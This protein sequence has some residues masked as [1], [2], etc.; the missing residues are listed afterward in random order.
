MEW[1]EDLKEAG[2]KYLIIDDLWHD[3]RNENGNLAISEISNFQFL[4]LDL[5][6]C[7]NY[8]KKT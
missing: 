6:K 8:K 2:Y 1:P 7:N 4:Y 3:G 5:A